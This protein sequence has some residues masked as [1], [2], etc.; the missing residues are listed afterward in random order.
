[1]RR[2]GRDHWK[3]RSRDCHT[4]KGHSKEKYVE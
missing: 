1:M 4:K 2:K 3:P